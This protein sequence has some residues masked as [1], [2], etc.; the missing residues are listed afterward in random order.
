MLTPLL[1]QS[2][3]QRPYAA[4][5]FVGCVFIGVV[6]TIYSAFIPLAEHVGSG[7]GS[8]VAVDLL[9]ASAAFVA[10]WFVGRGRISSFVSLQAT[11]VGVLAMTYATVLNEIL[12]A[13][14]RVMVLTAH[15][16][17]VLVGAVIVVRSKTLVVVVMCAAPALW[18][19]VSFRAVAPGFT[20]EEWGPTWLV[21]GG[22][23]WDRAGA[24]LD[25]A[26]AE[27]RV[28][29]L[30][31]LLNRRGGVEHALQHEALAR[32]LGE[33]V[34]CAFL[35]VDRFKSVN[36]R[37]G[38]AVGDEVLIAVSRAIRAVARESDV[39]V[40]WGG[41]EFLVFGIGATPER[42][43]LEERVVSALLPLDTSL[44]EFWDPQV[45]VGVAECTATGPSVVDQLIFEADEAMYQSRVTR[46][47]TQYRAPSG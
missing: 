43:E 45:T 25:R 17:I 11:V 16:C 5:I 28:D 14:E 37:F 27:S 24:N 33:S 42:G 30:T 6:S 38:H 18:L 46:R 4:A 34:W 35:D 12:V 44:T 23:E 47:G 8:I 7:Q 1:P 40:R 15:C 13:P 29:D 32:R 3:R 21:V 41:D 2:V 9:A 39:A 31:G 22:T 26:K 19:L 20:L 10:A 36:D